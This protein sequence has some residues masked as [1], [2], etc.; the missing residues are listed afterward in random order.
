[1]SVKVKR[2]ESTYIYRKQQQCPVPEARDSWIGVESQR[3]KRQFG[4]K[5]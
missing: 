2:G 5:S 3:Q 1:M 4:N